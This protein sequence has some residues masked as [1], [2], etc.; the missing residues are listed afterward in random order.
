MSAIP[1]ENAEYLLEYVRKL[2][3]RAGISPS[4]LARVENGI[5]T[6]GGL[7]LTLP[8]DPLQRPVYFYLTGLTAKPFW[9]SRQFEWVARLEAQYETIRS[10]L[11]RLRDNRAFGP[12]PQADLIEEGVWAEYH[13]FDHEKKLDQN[14]AQC[15]QTTEIIESLVDAKSCGLKYFSALAPETVIRPHCGPYNLRLRCHLGLVI[16]DDCRIR[17]GSETRFWEEGK[18]LIFDDSFF[19]ESWNRSNRTRVVLLIDF[20]HPDLTLLEIAFLRKLWGAVQELQDDSYN[21]WRVNKLQKSERS[22]L[23]ERWWI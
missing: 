11:L 14:C 1:S 16:P 2:A 9:D 17:V 13:L 23:P 7:D 19:H 20:I 21:N 3:N 5:Q 4:F 6:A 22:N 10:E 12:H 15:P 8:V 18:C